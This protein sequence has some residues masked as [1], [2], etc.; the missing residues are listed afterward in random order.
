MDCYSMNTVN[1]VLQSR[2]ALRQDRG[3]AVG[4]DTLK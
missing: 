1:R 4:N 2:F 3:Q